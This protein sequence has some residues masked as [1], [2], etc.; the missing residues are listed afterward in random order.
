MENRERAQTVKTRLKP[1]DNVAYGAEEIQKLDIY[2]PKDAKGCRYSSV[3]MAAVGL[4]VAKTHGPFLQKLCCQKESS[5]CLLTMDLR[6]SI[7][8]KI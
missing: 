6:L 8:W 3:F 2:A 5:L 1:I 4:W 7:G